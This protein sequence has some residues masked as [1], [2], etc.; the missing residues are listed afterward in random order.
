MFVGSLNEK[1]FRIDGEL[2]MNMGALKAALILSI[3]ESGWD[4]L[5]SDTDVVWLANPGDFFSL[6][7][8]MAFADVLVS[9]DSLS[10]SNDEAR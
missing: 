3:V 7:G 9:S 4:V 6:N 8:E 1:D 2:F 10:I 5:M